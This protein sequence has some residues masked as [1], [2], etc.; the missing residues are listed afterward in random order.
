[1]APKQKIG[2]RARAPSLAE[3]EDARCGPVRI[4]ALAG[5]RRVGLGFF[6]GHDSVVARLLL[7]PTSSSVAEI[8]DCVAVRQARAQVPCEL[9]SDAV[10][11]WGATERAADRL[12]RKRR[13]CVGSEEGAAYGLAIG[14]TM[15]GR[16]CSARQHRP[17][18]ILP[19]V[20]LLVVL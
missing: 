15:R 6:L 16:R 19:K 4:I 9:E 10:E 11:W 2:T 20:L 7:P 5:G 17:R 8:V 18:L 14:E 13:T 3:H 12:D 1:M